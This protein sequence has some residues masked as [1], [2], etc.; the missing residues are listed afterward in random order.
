MIN[1]IGKQL[2]MIKCKLQITPYFFQK[3]TARH[4]CKTLA[5]YSM[6]QIFISSIKKHITK[7]V[8]ESRLGE[9]LNPF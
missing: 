2:E 6:Y 1:V 7:A 8:T 9:L 3:Q 5:N 4:F